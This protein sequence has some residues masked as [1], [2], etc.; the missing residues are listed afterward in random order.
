M[1]DTTEFDV[2]G[3]LDTIASDLGFEGGSDD[4]GA[5]SDDVGSGSLDS[6]RG[7]DAVG[8]TDAATPVAG[9]GGSEE[10]S[11]ETAAPA[12]E[13]VPA[14]KTWRPEAVAAWDTLPETVQK[15][16]LKREEDIFKGLESYKVD[17]N[18]G[19]NVKGVFAPYEGIMAA[20]R[21]DPVAL[22]QNL[23]SAHHQLATGTMEQK[24]ALFHKLA[25]DYG[26]TLGDPADAPYADPEVVAL[27]QKLAEVES[28][29]MGWEQRQQAEARG[30]L[31]AELTS[32][33]SDP[34]HPYFD[35]VANDIAAIIRGGGAQDLASA[36]E[37]AVWANPVTRAK[38]QARIATEQ[39]AQTAKAAA[40]K[41]AEAKA[42]VAA[43]VR[44]KAKAASAATPLGSIDDTLAET[45]AKIQARS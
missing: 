3:A 7:T 37:K 29:T 41:A 2:A 21:I 6:D 5:G 31:E 38:E 42:S 32:F 20:N 22:T 36:Y 10:G 8:S 16:V 43:N 11:A 45:M 14:P 24:Q 12:V 25:A 9:V 13:K 23:L 40:Q 27:R 15:E 44:S 1:S 4:S 18:F 26:V 34:A 35:E 39:S 30:K 33:A 19:R 17:A 28:R